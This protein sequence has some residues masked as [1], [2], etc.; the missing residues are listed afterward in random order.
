MRIILGPELKL[1][2][3]PPFNR[4]GTGDSKHNSVVADSIDISLYL[5]N[6][7]TVLRLHGET[8]GISPSA[9]HCLSSVLLKHSKMVRAREGAKEALCAIWAGPGRMGQRIPPV[10]ANHL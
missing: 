7:L 2:H 9:L 4:M 10:F 8:K 5:V 3:S 1:T 6:D